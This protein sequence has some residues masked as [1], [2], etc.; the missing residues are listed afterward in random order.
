[1]KV[2]N[3]LQKENLSKVGMHIK[4]ITSML[5]LDAF[6]PQSLIMVSAV[7]YDAIFKNIN[8]SFNVIY[9]AS[10]INLINM[11]NIF[12][13]SLCYLLFSFLFKA[14]EVITILELED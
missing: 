7:P 12:L 4:K 5:R 14:S 2:K 9:I 11:Q 3:K 1:M 6:R 8:K 13:F 10:H